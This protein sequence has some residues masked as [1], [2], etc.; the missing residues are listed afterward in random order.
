MVC[1]HEHFKDIFLISSQY[2]NN[3]KRKWF[4]NI[5]YWHKEA[6][7]WKTL[8]QRKSSQYMKNMKNVNSTSNFIYLHWHFKDKYL[9]LSQYNINFWRKWFLHIKYWHK[10]AILWKILSQRKS[11]QYM[12]NMKNFKLKQIGFACINTS[13]IYFWFQVN[14]ISTLGENDF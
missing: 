2:N 7:L 5:K 10:E 8:S 6:I 14:T 11:S 1:L 9:I 3:F 4:L 13:K 12:K